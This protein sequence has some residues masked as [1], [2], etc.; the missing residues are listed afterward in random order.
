[1]FKILVRIVVE[2]FLQGYIFIFGDEPEILSYAG[3]FFIIY[4]VCVL[5]FAMAFYEWLTDGI[6]VD[7]RVRHWVERW[8]RRR[9][10]HQ[11]ARRRLQKK[12]MEERVRMN[13]IKEREGD[14]DGHM[15][16]V[17]RGV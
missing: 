5:I 7:L 9:R 4:S 14:K 12:K 2:P 13:M 11:R 16:T 17:R 1:M 10:M 3:L 8:K 6:H 15:M